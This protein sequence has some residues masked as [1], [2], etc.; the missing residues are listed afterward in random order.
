MDE[1]TAQGG[2]N[3]VLLQE[4]V[5][6][7]LAHPA[8]P[9]TQNPRLLIGQLPDTL[10]FDLPLPTGSRVLGSLQRSAE[11]AEVIVDVPLAQ[12][13]TLAFYR[14]QMQASGWL[15]EEFPPGVRAGGFVSTGFPGIGSMLHLHQGVRGPSLRLHAVPGLAG[16]TEVRLHIDLSGRDSPAHRSRMRRQQMMGHNLLPPLPAPAGARQTGGGG[17]GGSDSYYSSAT[18]ETDADLPTL[19]TH[20]AGQLE[21]AGW[22]Q[23]DA[24]QSGPLAWH[25]WT[26]Q[27]EDGEPWR[28]LFFILKIPGAERQY[29]LYIRVDWANKSSE[30]RGGFSWAPMSFGR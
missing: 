5:L 17:G 28:G 4:L 29:A 3:E 6:R 12:E 20:Y 23:I 2:G 22:S 14:A 13:E 7:L 9:R 8:D 27:D 21:K 10:P 25:A 1:T 30:M 24:G 15:E 26:F 16:Q 11:H 19:T 18:L